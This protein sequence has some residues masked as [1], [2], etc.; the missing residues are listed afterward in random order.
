MP[1]TTAP[2]LRMRSLR[3]W[4]WATFGE[5]LSRAVSP[6]TLIVLTR[7]LVPADY[8]VYVGALSIV[9]FCQMVVESGFVRALVQKK[10]DI[11]RIA[12]SAFTF[13]VLLGTA[14]GVLL[15]ALSGP[16]SRLLTGEGSGRAVIAAMALLVPVAGVA[17]IHRALL[18]RELRFRAI[19]A[20]RLVAVI[21][22]AIVSISLAS[23]GF[24][25]WALVSGGLAGI[26]CE[27]AVLAKSSGFRSRPRL[28]RSDLAS[29]WTFSAW[30]LGQDLLAWVVLYADTLLVAAFLDL[31]QLGKYRLGSLLVAGGFA[32]LFVPAEKVLFSVFSK[33]SDVPSVA[34]V[35]YPLLFAGVLIAFPVGLTL[36]AVHE[37]IE[38]LVFPDKWAGVGLVIG[39]IGLFQAL[40]NSVFA[41]DAAYKGVGRPD[42]I[43]KVRI[44]NVVVLMTLQVISLQ[45]SFEA[46]LVARIAGLVVAFAV[47]VAVARRFFGRSSMVLTRNHWLATGL[48]FVVFVL[49]LAAPAKA[50]WHGGVVVA[51]CLAL[52]PYSVFVTRV[53]RSTLIRSS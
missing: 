26:L 46:F 34:R 28:S 40:A 7:L 4:K 11:S 44:V 25:V 45:I 20:S 1:A 33:F 12:A 21:A 22:V 3:A 32:A 17:A 13:V 43:F 18:E 23:Q 49:A 47:I 16:V 9:A 15:V 35:F 48:L 42:I 6:I 38:S 31:D 8:G 53:L 19:F 52:I 50:E 51:L 24:G 30:T 29:V 27:A 5:L 37:E 14:L 10:G 41:V 39:L 2:S 36:F